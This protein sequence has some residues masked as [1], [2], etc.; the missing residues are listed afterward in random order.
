MKD[1]YCER[2]IADNQARWRIRGQAHICLPLVALLEGIDCGSD[3][4]TYN[5]KQM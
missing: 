2:H 1:K 3:G 5:H 4:T